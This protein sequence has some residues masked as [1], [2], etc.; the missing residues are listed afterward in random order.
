MTP[1]RSILAFLTLVL[2]SVAFAQPA[3]A[4]KYNVLFLISDDLRA[5]LGS[6]GGLAKTPN[7]D[8]LANKAVRFE[9]AYC[10]YPLCNPSR[11]SLLTG[12]YPSNNGVIGN[13]DN[14]RDVHPDW[15][16]LPRLF[17]DNG[18]PSLR[19][20]KIFHGIDWLD[21]PNAWTEGGTFKPAPEPQAAAVARDRRNA[22]GETDPDAATRRP[23]ATRP[24]VATTSA[25]PVDHNS[26]EYLLAGSA[27]VPGQPAQQARSD[28]W[29]AI[30]D[31]PDGGTAGSTRQAIDYLNR[32]KDRQFFLACG[33]SKP[34]SPL[35]TSLRFFQEYDY[36][37][38]PLPVD[39]QTKPTLPAGFPQGS[40]R[41]G[42]ADL[43]VGRHDST[44]ET[45]RDM[46]RAYLAC[47][48]SVDY[49]VGQVLA[50]LDRL[51]LA[52]KT[53]I[54]FWGDHGYQLGEKGK[55]SKAGS[56][57]EQGSRVPFVIYVPGL[58]GMG[59]SSPRVVESLDLYRTLGDLLGLNVADHVQGR[60]L[61][62]LLKDP[63]AAWD[64]P[65]FTV[66]SEDG[67]T[68]T[69]ISVR[70]EKFRYAEFTASS[71]GAML[72][73]EINDP[74][75]LKNIVDDPAYAGVRAELAKLVAE[76]RAGFKPKP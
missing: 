53:I 29:L 34:H 54:V 3:A 22:D 23:P 52:D 4:P 43:F 36:D 61:V 35:E 57:W 28:R 9:R 20:G 39:Y 1:I 76:Y 48:T 12:H 55:W 13:R 11:A 27:P 75:E 30:D 66:W 64:H 44:P 19:T 2:S 62:P 60:S 50:E 42:N 18:I 21:D 72:L 6:Y 49:N 47:T 5:E 17:K 38:I 73:D 63:A 37:Q 31:G 24:V 68:L 58:G 45:A 51:K 41:P 32:Y 16:T 8:A 33:Y 65:A 69:A 56:V 74:H 70:N 40:I 15:V 67:R 14:W 59:K 26:R 7:L 71:G 10:Q 46:I 25:G